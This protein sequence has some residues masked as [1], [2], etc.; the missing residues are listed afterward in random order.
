MRLLA[1]LLLTGCA[2]AEPIEPGDVLELGPEP[3]P[4]ASEVLVD[5][6]AP[7]GTPLQ[8]DAVWISLAPDENAPARCMERE[9]ETWIASVP[10][11]EDATAYAEVCGFLYL[12]PV[13]MTSASVHVT[14]TADNTPC[15]PHRTPQ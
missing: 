15:A 11:E 6:A 3:P 1:F 7:D 12:E 9:C 8:A 4:L 2:A 10:A 5:V 13:A 14:V